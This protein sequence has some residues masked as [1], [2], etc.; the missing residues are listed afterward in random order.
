M[1]YLQPVLERLDVNV[2]RTQFHR[3]LDDQ[4]DQPDHRRFGRQVAQVLDIVEA[5]LAFRTI[6]DAFHRTAAL[7]MPALDQFVNLAAHRHRRARF[8]PAG[9]AHCL[10]HVIV[11]RIGQQHV[12]VFGIRR[13][14]HHVELLHELDA[15]RDVF[16][17]QFR[18][19]LGAAQRQVQL[20][21]TG[22]GMVA[23]GDQAQ[24]A[25]QGQQPTT[26]LLLQAPR[27]GEVGVFQ[28]AALQEQCGNAL[29][30]AIGNCDL[31]RDC[32]HVNRLR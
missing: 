18:H 31:V 9:Q 14:R 11:L 21:G 12:D 27:A 17:R 23:F 15:Q 32:A 16:R 24:P 28:L 8:A 2:R 4:V 7:A 5:F 22:L 10:Q 30:R 6:D 20:G 29:V 25:E 19:I 1:R 3:T 26:G 13:H